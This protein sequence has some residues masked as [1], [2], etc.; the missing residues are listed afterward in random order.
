M[1]RDGRTK[2]EIDSLRNEDRNEEKPH[3]TQPEEQKKASTK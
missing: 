2:T 3:R 1:P